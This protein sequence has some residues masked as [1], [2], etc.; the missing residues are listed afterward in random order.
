MV[1]AENGRYKK[2]KL[3]KNYEWI[4]FG[5]FVDAKGASTVFDI[6]TAAIFSQV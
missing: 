2:Y 1:A 5:T 4:S 3:T 6:F